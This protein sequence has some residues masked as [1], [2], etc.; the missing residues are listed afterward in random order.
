M[1]T[2][3][4]VCFLVA[5]CALLTETAQAQTANPFRPGRLADIVARHRADML[6]DVPADG[7]E[8]VFAG[9]TEPTEVEA[10]FAGQARPLSASRHEFITA[11]AQSQGLDPRWA[12]AF[13]E[14]WLFRADS[15]QYW[16]AV[17][18]MTAES[19]R[20]VVRAGDPITLYTR[21]LGARV[22][23]GEPQWIF[24]L[25]SASSDREAAADPEPPDV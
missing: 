11:W 6:D 13:T 4:S 2:M 18:G 22:E 19:M 12:A 17:Q 14:E 16:L 24:L 25:I 20:P 3:R 10:H 8:L 7:L 1:T 23:R 5:S 9:N 15:G 21:W